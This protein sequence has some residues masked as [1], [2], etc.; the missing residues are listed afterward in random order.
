M[1]NLLAFAAFAAV[2]TVCGAQRGAASYVLDEATGRISAFGA[3]DGR[4]CVVG[5]ENRYFL[6]SRS[7]DVE[8]F[9]RTCGLDLLNVTIPYKRTAFA[10]CDELTPMARRL[11]NVN[12]V[13]RG[14][15]GRLVG[16]NTDAYGF[17][18]LIDS[19]G[20]EV[21][22]RRCAILGAGGAA[23][24]AQA[25]L[26]SRG[27]ARVTFVRR[28][29][30]PRPDDEIIVNATPVGMF[31]DVDG[32]RIDIAAYPGCATVLDLVYNPSPTRLVREAR[33]CGK[34]AADGLVMLIAQAYGAFRGCEGTGEE[35]TLYLYGPPASGKST[36]A[37]KVSAATGWPLADLDAEIVRRAGRSIPEIFATEGEA[38]FRAREKLTLAAIAARPGPQVVALG[39][40]A[41]L[42]VE[43][44]ALAERTGRVV[45]LDC[46]AETL[47]ARLTGPDRPLSADPAKL[48]ALLARRREHYASF[49]RRIRF[50][51]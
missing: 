26:E 51:R 44:R 31:P 3:K 14:A 15:D 35:R 24:T 13:T 47:K 30:T 7:G 28:G 23:L 1:K 32:A 9:V 42:D 43:S 38:A 18:R 50:Q 5:I 10:M 27:A 29:E 25:V 33:A 36:L 49:A 40:G 8:A 4:T 41:L 11:G 22:G 17:G 39:G 37:A 2:S 20:A 21:R 45:L 46:A 12:L 16:D 19:V 48:E 6:M 34:A